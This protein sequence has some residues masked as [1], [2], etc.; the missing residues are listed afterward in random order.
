MIGNGKKIAKKKLSTDYEQCS[1]CGFDHGYEPSQAHDEHNR[2]FLD[3][4][5]PDHRNELFYREELRLS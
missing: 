2:I 3:E 4:L 1:I 5:H